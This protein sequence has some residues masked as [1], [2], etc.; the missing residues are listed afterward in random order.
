MLRSLTSKEAKTAKARVKQRLAERREL[1][2]CLPEILADVA[3]LVGR[4]TH[5]QR[6]QCPLLPATS[7]KRAACHFVIKDR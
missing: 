2:K 4:N 3:A 6:W 5:P 7:T 1:R